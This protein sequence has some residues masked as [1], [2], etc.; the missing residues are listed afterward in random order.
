MDVLQLDKTRSKG[1][2]R[3]ISNQKTATINWK[4]RDCFYPNQFK[5]FESCCYS[6]V[7]SPDQTIQES[8]MK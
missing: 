4:K 6:L 8:N 2:N 5:V 7:R 3:I 1:F